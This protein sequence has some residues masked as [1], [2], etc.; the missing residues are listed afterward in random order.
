[1]LTLPLIPDKRRK[2]AACKPLE[3]LP[4]AHES[5]MQIIIKAVRY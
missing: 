1:M 4:E 2:Q 3:S 5:V